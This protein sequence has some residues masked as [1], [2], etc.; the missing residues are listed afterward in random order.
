MLWFHAV[1]VLDISGT[2]IRKL[3][4]TGKDAAFLMPQGVLDIIS[5]EGLYATG[6]KNEE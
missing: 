2:Q 4:A 5:R 1:T 6:S 3:L